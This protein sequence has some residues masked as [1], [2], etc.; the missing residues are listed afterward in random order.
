MSYVFP[1]NNWCVLLLSHQF[2]TIF[3]GPKLLESTANLTIWTQLKI[4]DRRVKFK[5]HGQN[6]TRVP[7]L[8]PFYLFLF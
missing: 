7:N 3:H 1:T 6:N 4:E 5:D 2:L 8:F